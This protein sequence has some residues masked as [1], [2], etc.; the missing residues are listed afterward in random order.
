MKF[1]YFSFLLVLVIFL[2]SFCKDSSNANKEKES[3][4]IALSDTKSI[5]K[6]LGYFTLNVKGTVTKNDNVPLKQTDNF[7]VQNIKTFKNSIAD[8]Q[9]DPKNI[10]RKLFIYSNSDIDLD[11]TKM[12]LNNGEIDFY[13][14]SSNDKGFSIETDWANLLIPAKEDVSLKL[15]FSKEKQEFYVH[16]FIG[17]VVIQP[18]DKVLDS[19]LSN[20]QLDA[21]TEG[22]EF[23]F[24]KKNY[25]T[26]IKIVKETP[27]KKL[28]ISQLV[29][30][31]EHTEDEKKS[32][33][34]RRENQIFLNEEDLKEPNQVQSKLKEKIKIWE[35]KYGDNH[36]AC[37]FKHKQSKVAVIVTFQGVKGYLIQQNGQKIKI[38]P[39]DS[40]EPKT[41]TI[42]SGESVNF[43]EV[44][45]C[46]VYM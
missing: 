44:K 33:K 46:K 30:V 34:N 2:T 7:S 8:L 29:I 38:Q 43:M 37:K 17:K 12:K 22:K 21:G 28:D 20:N 23:R 39:S 9:G 10:R 16:V 14:E 42:D 25:E 15:I 18:V 40:S 32:H 36:Y 26:I 31:R 4:K 45:N 11:K 13:V 35:E 3:T 41:Y 6:E 1:F 27:S 5:P 24:T 19:A